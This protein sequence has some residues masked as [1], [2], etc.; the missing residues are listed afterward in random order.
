MALMLWLVG[1]KK[2]MMSL[3]RHAVSQTFLTNKCAAHCYDSAPAIAWYCWAPKDG[4]QQLS[5]VAD[6]A[7]LQLQSITLPQR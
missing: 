7:L 1:M 4:M 6:N 5:A 3:I 2:M